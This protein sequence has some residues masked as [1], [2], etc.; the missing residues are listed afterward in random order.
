MKNDFKTCHYY[1]RRFVA[2][3]YIFKWKTQDLSVARFLKQSTSHLSKLEG[4]LSGIAT[5][6]VWISH[7]KGKNQDTEY[8][9]KPVPVSLLIDTRLS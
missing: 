6:R 1:F 2:P 3:K 9:L 8:Q 7:E 5:V 4:L